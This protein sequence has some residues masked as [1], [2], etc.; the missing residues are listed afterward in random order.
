METSQTGAL[1]D[2]PVQC[3]VCTTR[4]VPALALVT[5]WSLCPVV[6]L[7]DRSPCR[8]TSTGCM[9]AVARCLNTAP[10][11]RRSCTGSPLDFRW[12]CWSDVIC[13]AEHRR[14]PLTACSPNIL[15]EPAARHLL[16]IH[17]AG[18]FPKSSIWPFCGKC[19]SSGDK[20]SV[21]L[22]MWKVVIHRSG[23]VDQS[24][25]IVSWLIVSQ[26]PTLFALH[27]LVR[28][29]LQ[30]MSTP[31]QADINESQSIAI[32]QEKFSKW[33]RSV[34]CSAIRTPVAKCV[35]V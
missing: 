23:T 20:T 3:S 9:V 32:V 28:L 31:C 5:R 35:T 2:V 22:C 15:H 7:L 8:A 25:H 14:W 16:S 29:R 4:C 17:T 6:P 26:L 24:S 10:T 12:P 34:R 30:L 18:Y 1:I 19:C 27:R 21:G 11:R 13:A 33:S